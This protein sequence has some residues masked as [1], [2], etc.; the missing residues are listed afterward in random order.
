MH[1][2]GALL[3]IQVQKKRV[4]TAGV[5]ESVDAGPGPRALADALPPHLGHRRCESG[6]LA[7]VRETARD[8]AAENTPL[9]SHLFPCL[10]RACLG[11]L[12]KIWKRLFKKGVFRT[13]AGSRYRRSSWRRP[14]RRPP[15]PP[16]RPR[17]SARAPHRSPRAPGSRPCG[18]NLS[19]SSVSLCLSRACLGELIIPMW[20]HKKRFPHPIT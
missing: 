1:A 13:A 2:P 3:I 10:S 14:G 6:A 15:W 19:C 8:G 11:K 9:F 17:T 4:L 5:V 7:N 16:R 20:L 18:K 12:I